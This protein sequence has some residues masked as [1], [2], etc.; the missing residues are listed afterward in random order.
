LSL[1]FPVRKYLILI[2][3]RWLFGHPTVHERITEW[4]FA[5][6]LYRSTTS[7]HTKKTT[8]AICS[9]VTGK[10]RDLW[11]DDDGDLW[12]RTAGAGEASSDGENWDRK[13][14]GEGS[15]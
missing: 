11:R 7:T 9:T 10:W 6:E 5:R 3:T 13:S 4:L 8:A 15:D 14:R 2:I 12:V 1:Y